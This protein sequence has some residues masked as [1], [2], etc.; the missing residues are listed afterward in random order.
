MSNQTLSEKM[1]ELFSTDENIQEWKLLGKLPQDIADI[2]ACALQ[3]KDTEKTMALQ[4]IGSH[5]DEITHVA[6]LIQQE[7]FPDSPPLERGGFMR[8]LAGK[9]PAPN[10]LLWGQISG[11]IVREMRRRGYEVEVNDPLE[12]IRPENTEPPDEDS[13]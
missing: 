3:P 12:K 2:A 6:Q 1:E 4:N 7:F 5:P 13:V 10:W 8:A 9:G 11:Q